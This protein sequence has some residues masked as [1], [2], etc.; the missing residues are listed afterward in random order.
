MNTEHLTAQGF[1][2]G[3]QGKKGSPVDRVHHHPEPAAQDS[4]HIDTAQVKDIENMEAG[5]IGQV[6]APGTAHGN[7]RGDRHLVRTSKKDGRLVTAQKTAVAAD[8][9]QTVILYRVMRGCQDDGPRQALT[10]NQEL[11]GGGR[12]QVGDH[13]LPT[14]PAQRL[15]HHRHQFRTVGAAVP[16]QEDG[17]R[18]LEGGESLGVGIHHPVIEVQP[19]FAAHP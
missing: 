18:W 9:F 13:Q 8:E 6:P 1:Q 7:L 10:G 2:K 3:R 5:S 19:H 14:D 16:G 4:L 12:H 17:T 11:G 15:S